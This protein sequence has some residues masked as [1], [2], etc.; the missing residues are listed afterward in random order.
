[1]IRHI[2]VFG[3]VLAQASLPAVATEFDLI[4]P[5]AA[6]ITAQVVQPMASVELPSGPFQNGAMT[7]QSLQAPMSQTAFRIASPLATQDIM[8]PLRDQM[9]A[10]GFD[11]V[12]EC[13]TRQCGGFD[14]RFGMDVLPE[15]EMH[16]DLGDFRYALAQRDGASVGVMVSR[17]PNFGFVQVTR[18]GDIALAAP[19]VTESSK[20]PV[21]TA[22]PVADQ[23]TVLEDLIFDSGSAELTAGDYPSLTSL[24]QTLTQTPEAALI[25]HG[26]TDS[27][28]NA[29]A[30][31]ALSQARAD[32]LR[33]VLVGRYGIDA[34]RITA[35]G[36]GDSTPRASNATPEGRAKNRR[37][38][39]LITTDPARVLHS[40][41]PENQ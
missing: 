18:L 32:Q 16:V 31:L 14:F 41:A 13:E 40:A 20:S 25:I 12:F 2:V 7:T 36:L 34:A 37:I 17:S 35:L 38:E 11:M 29:A 22:P 28:G 6:E 5:E 10:A 8:T 15:P 27:S 1:M 21:L 3:I 4:L 33:D 19:K 24:A 30:N 39:V 23:T 9:H 26:F